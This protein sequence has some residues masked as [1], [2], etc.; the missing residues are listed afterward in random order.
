MLIVVVQFTGELVHYVPED[1]RVQ[2]LSQDVQQVPISHLASPYDGIDIVPPDESESHSHHI[3]SHSGGEDD[4]ESVEKSDKSE[5]AE[6]DEPEPEKDVDLL[7]DHVEGQDA[8]RV[9]ALHL[10]GGAELVEQRAFDHSV[11]KKSCYYIINYWQTKTSRYPND[12]SADSKTRSHR[13][14]PNEF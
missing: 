3:D 12:K 7:V 14:N 9:V 2:V 4:D 1:Y 6:K 11:E 5:E 10:A 13:F 8:E